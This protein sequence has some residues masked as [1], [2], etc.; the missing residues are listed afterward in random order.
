[1][2]TLLQGALKREADRRGGRAASVLAIFP[3]RARHEKT[4][5]VLLLR[6]LIPRLHRP[7]SASYVRVPRGWR[8]RTKW[9][10]S[11]AAVQASTTHG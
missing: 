1:M 8:W 4:A 2:G 5:H 10:H 6:P 3:C 11:Q 7:A 9:R